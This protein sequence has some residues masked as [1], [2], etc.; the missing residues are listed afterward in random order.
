[1]HIDMVLSIFPCNMIVNDHSHHF[2]S[3]WRLFCASGQQGTRRALPGL[4]LRAQERTHSSLHVKVNL[5]AGG[6]KKV[7]GGIVAG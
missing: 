3:L 4:L 6:K 7:F 2:N 5:S 1:M